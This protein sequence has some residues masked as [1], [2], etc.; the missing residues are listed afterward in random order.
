MSNP[1]LNRVTND[2]QRG[3]A[4]FRESGVR[5]QQGYGA[6]GYAPQQPGPYGQ[7]GYGRPQPGFGEPGSAPGLGGDGGGGRAITLDD[8]IMRTGALF[9]VLVAVAAAAVVALDK[10][11]L[12][13]RA[14]DD[15]SPAGT[16]RPGSARQRRRDLR[17]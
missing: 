9:A 2:A 14:R 7:P 5:T 3:Y 1:L 12:R 8:V 15:R 17:R 10:R 16:L 4:G 13:G 6:Q 11:R